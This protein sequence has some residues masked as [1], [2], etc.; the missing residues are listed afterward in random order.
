MNCKCY[1]NPLFLGCINNCQP[2]ILNKTSP[3]V[4]VFVLALAYRG[5]TVTVNAVTTTAAEPLIFDISELNADFTFE[6]SVIAPD[7]TELPIM[8]NAITYDGIRF[9]T[10]IGEPNTQSKTI[11]D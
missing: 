1:D 6:G 7:G 5:R 2:L 8:L 11:Q 10:R 3:Q 4:G 9:T